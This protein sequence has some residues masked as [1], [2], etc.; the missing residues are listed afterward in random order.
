LTARTI[1]VLSA[2]DVARLLPMMDCI[3]VMEQAFHALAA[4]D[5]VQPLRQ[6]VHLPDGTGSLYCMPAYLDAAG[7]AALAVK[8]ITLFP[9]NAGTA[10][11]SHQG[12]IV[13]FGARQG[14]VLA[15]I[16][17]AS[18]TAV[19]TAAVSALA[20]RLLALPDA[21]DLAILG[22]GVQARSHLEAM[23]AVRP[24]RRVRVW[25]RTPAH[26]RAFAAAAAAAHAITPEVMPTPEDAVRGAT[27]ICCAT[28]SPDPVVQGAWLA[29]GAHINAVGSSTPGAR[30]LDTEAVARARV[31]VDSREAALAEAG[32]LLIPLAQGAFTPAHIAGELAELVAGRVPGRPDAQEIT[33][34]KSL[35][36]AIEDVAAARHIHARLGVAATTGA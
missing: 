18:V 2:A 5:A 24:V 19:R 28:G 26:A 30:E 7:G 13:L 29:P 21:G 20:T 27:L 6:V 3:A 15:L 35:G 14:E 16:D 32:D 34:F 11:E 36:L 33:L 25:S 31:F 17:A 12:V 23:L 8:L 4:G 9:G 22:A 1:P 10:F